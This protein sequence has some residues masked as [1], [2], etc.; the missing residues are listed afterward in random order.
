MIRANAGECVKVN[1]T[2]ELD[3]EGHDGLPTTPAPPCGLPAYPTTPRPPTAAWLASTPTPPSGS[4]SPSPTSGRHQRRKGL[5]FFRDEATTATSEANSGSI[6]HGLYGASPSSL[7][8]RSGG[9]RRRA[10]RSTMEPQSTTGSPRQA[11]TLT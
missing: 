11:A 3:P 10:A 8:A 1:F 5:Y 9:T 2:N 4:V 6:S 7:Q